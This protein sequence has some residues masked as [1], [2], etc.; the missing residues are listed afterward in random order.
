MKK[1][2][3]LFL[4]MVLSLSFFALTAGAFVGGAIPEYDTGTFNAADC[5][6]Y[7]RLTKSVTKDGDGTDTTT[8][9]YNDAGLLT[10][11]TY[12]SAMIGTSTNTFVYDENCNVTKWEYKN[13]IGFSESAVY[14]YDKNGNAVKQTYTVTEGEG[15]ESS[16]VITYTYNSKG[17]LTKEV[18]KSEWGS[19]TSTY[20]YDDAGNLIKEIYKSGSDKSTST[21]SYNADGSLASAKQEGSNGNYEAAFTYNSKGDPLTTEY[22]YADG[23][24]FKTTCKYDS[25]GR[26]TKESTVSGG[27]TTTHTYTYDSKGRL[28]KEAYKTSS[29]YSFTHTYTYDSNGNLTKE[30]YTSGDYSSVTTNTYK[31]V[32]KPIVS[33]GQVT[34]QSASVAYSGSPKTPAVL[35]GGAIRGADYRL[36]YSN[37]TEPGKATVTIKFKEPAMGQ[38]KVNFTVTPRKV[39]G[40]KAAAVKTNSI[41]VS[42]T[43]LTEAKAYKV[44][45]SSNGKTWKSA[46]VTGNTYTLKS[47]KAGSKWQFRVTALDATKKIKGETSKVLKTGTKT[48]APEISKLTSDKAKTATVTWGKVTGAAKYIVYKSTDG[49]TFK[50]AA[51]TTKLTYTLTKLTAGKKIYVKI[52]AVNAYGEKSAAGAVKSVTVK[53]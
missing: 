12:K 43:K 9:T 29:D 5:I 48:A 41:K 15:S 8:Y 45:Y 22:T 51:T 49:K 28:T 33:T 42:W 19:S 44:E 24:T 1:L 14:A 53:K 7:Y 23:D 18:T 20:T 2:T 10:Q 3:A 21:Y 52:V 17:F 50:K 32:S 35:V 39:T 4:A 6:T 16:S 38:I 27:E 40:L 30:T 47:L 26:L 31:K 46:T 37:N 36:Q 25:K 11:S 13:P 34:M